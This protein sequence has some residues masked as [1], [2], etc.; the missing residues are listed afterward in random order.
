MTTHQVDIA[1]IGGGAA[2]L[3]AVREA[4][5]RGASAL[6]V[7]RGPLGGD[8]T[9]TGCVP[10]KS[11][12]EAARVGASFAEAFQRARQVVEQIAATETPDVLRAEGIVVLD[13]EGV[14]VGPGQIRAG[15][16]SVKA[17][18]VVLA[19]GGRPVLPPISGLAESGVLTTDTIWELHEAPSSLTIIGGGAIGCELGQALATLG[20]SVTLVELAPRLLPGEEVQASAIIEQELRSSGVNVYTGVS[21]EQVEVSP[22]GQR[23]QLSDG[24]S[25]VTERV[26]VAAGRK[27]SSDRGALSE[28]GVELDRRGYIKVGDD[29]ATNLRHTYAAGDITGKLQLTHAAD[30]MGRIA[31]T[32]ILRRVGRA[33]FRAEQIPRVTFTSPEVAS[34]GLSEGEAARMLRGARVAELPLAEHD[35]AVAADMTN[36]YLKLISGPKG[37]LGHLGGGRLVGATIVAERAGEMMAELALALRLRVFIGRLA[38]TTHPYP[39]WSYAIPK[40]AAQF[41]TTIESREAR[42]A[43]E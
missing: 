7:N 9:F 40:V 29:L 34:I 33:R 23:L 41:F 43:K 38:M 32:N 14:L 3:A 22:E 20:V 18:G 36:G 12:I 11:V 31:A 28:T 5:R 1:V 13:E 16:S 21:V 26:L 10:S 24:S 4:R 27:P 25:L 30:A 37:V 2:G 42:P 15:T 19:L 6:I 35:R 8:C 39:T 17:R